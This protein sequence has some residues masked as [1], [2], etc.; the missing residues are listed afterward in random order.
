M[1][2]NHVVGLSGRLG[3]GK[4]SLASNLAESSGWPMASF[5]DYLRYLAEQRVLGVDRQSLQQLGEEQIAELGWDGFCL[6]VLK[7]FKWRPG[8]ALVLDGIRHTKVVNALKRL[9][10]PQRLFLVHLAI[11]EKIRH[12]RLLK[13]DGIQ[14]QRKKLEKL[15][16]HS[17]EADVKEALP[18]IADMIVDATL[19]PEFL[20][21]EILYAVESTS[22][23][24]Q[25]RPFLA[26][27]K[28]DSLSA[29]FRS[30]LNKLRYRNSLLSR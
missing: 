13:R 27:R 6:A 5:G 1:L 22:A 10:Y 20:A 15:E 14:A 12:N 9:I 3:S 24:H 25:P 7:Y 2:C 18:R 4:S 11:D 30:E 28:F 29:I 16:K 26:G 21:D 19:S 8:Q 17:T 23:P